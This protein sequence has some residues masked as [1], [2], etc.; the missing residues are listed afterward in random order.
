MFATLRH[1]ARFVGI[2]RILARHD[3]LFVIQVLSL[4]PALRPVKI[5]FGGRRGNVR[6]PGLRLAAALQEMGPSFIKLGQALS[7]R[8]DLL[9]ERFAADLAT[10]QD[11]LPPFPGE[12]ARATVE[13]E[14]GRPVEECFHEFENTPVAAASIAQ[15]HFAVTAEGETVAVKVLRP[16]IESA[17][18]ADL[19]LFYW[20]ARMTLR[21]RPQMQRFKPVEAV[22]MMEKT[23]AVEM[24]MRMEAAAASEL[25]ENFAD[26]PDFHVPK[27]NWPLTGQRVLT[28]ERV[29]GVRVDELDGLAHAEIE[30]DQILRKTT[31]ALFL[32]VFRDGFFHADP[33]PGNIFVDNTGRVAMVDFGIMGRLDE[34]T[35]IY[36]ADMLTG[37]LEGDYAKV[38]DAHFRAGYVPASQVQQDFAQ[39]CRAIGEPI[40]DLPLHEISIARLLSQ[41]FQVAEK[42]EME[43]QPQLLLLQKTMLVAEGVGR[44]L[45]PHVNMWQI[46]R[47]LI[48]DWARQHQ[49][50][51][52][53][54][55]LVADELF[56]LAERLPDIVRD[57]ERAL[58]YIARDGFKSHPYMAQETERAMNAAAGDSDTS[59]GKF[60]HDGFASG[61]ITGI[62]LAGIAAAAVLVFL[63]LGT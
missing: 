46:T 63:A 5:L 11:R 52:G 47:P 57:V 51:E 33:H 22:R 41:L 14:L 6:R 21:G 42:F 49:G 28:L 39:A 15:V 10:L 7:T 1:T 55:R 56:A 9:G 40:L 25:R 8:S 53:R 62:A 13:I 32:Q 12:Q 23:V 59:A 38:A 4:P 27:V 30:P 60:G 3:A 18:A 43:V 29:S 17:F 31:S 50:A 2:I 48:E 24:D 36:L 16:G 26:D 44:S 61:L 34:K 19:S 45:N 35:R 58:A 20:L 54:L 37:F